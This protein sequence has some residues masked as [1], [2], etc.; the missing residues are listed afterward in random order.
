MYFSPMY[1]LPGFSPWSAAEQEPPNE[2]ARLNARAGV[3]WAFASVNVRQPRIA[4][5][6]L[7]F[8]SEEISGN[9]AFTDGVHSSL[10]MAGEVVPGHRFVTGFCRH[11]PAEKD[12]SAADEWERYV[13]S[14]CESRVN[15]YRQS[16][17]S[18]GKL[19]EVFR[20]HALPDFIAGLEVE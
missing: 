15:A 12:R 20:Y 4:A 9:D 2:T 7:K 11:S 14:D 10:I 13:G 19:G 17:R 8:R 16:L 6:F 18:H 5:N 3:A 1:L